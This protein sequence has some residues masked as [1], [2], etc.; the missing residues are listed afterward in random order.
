[1]L[2]VHAWLPELG[3]LEAE[4]TATEA[5]LLAMAEHARRGDIKAAN[6][7]A[8][9]MLAANPDNRT[10]YLILMFRHEI[11]RR[12]VLVAGGG[13]ESIDEDLTLIRMI[14]SRQDHSDQKEARKLAS[15]LGDSRH[16]EAMQ[17]T[18]TIMNR[19]LEMVLTSR[20]STSSPQLLHRRA[21][22]ERRGRLLYRACGVVWR[23]RTVDATRSRRPR[24]L[25]QADQCPRRAPDPE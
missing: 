21:D 16:F 5:K 3:P 12:S 6:D 9:A 7:S 20:Y 14:L 1:M 15:D 25:D 17:N 11:T 24:A 13:D 2:F 4:P 10:R 8:T 22:H 23:A 19:C 18:E